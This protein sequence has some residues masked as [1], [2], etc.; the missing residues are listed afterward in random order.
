[1]K[2]LLPAEATQ[3]KAGTTTHSASAAVYTLLA[4]ASA[5]PLGLDDWLREL[6]EVLRARRA[7]LVAILNGEVVVQYCFPNEAGLM[8]SV[9]WPWQYERQSLG[10][11]AKPGPAVPTRSADGCSSFLTVAVPHEGIDWFLRL[12][13]TYHRTWTTDEEAALTL[14][15]LGL[16]Q[17]S[18]VQRSAQR[19]LPWSQRGQAQQR[20]EDAAALVSH[21]AHDFN[22]VL[23]SVLGFTELSLTQPSPGSPVHRLLTEVYTAAQQGSQLINRLS[24]FSSRKAVRDGAKASLGPAADEEMHRLRQA[25]GDAI[26]LEIAVPP[27]LPAL[28][29]DGESLRVLLHHLVENAREAIA[30]TGTVRLAAREVELTRLD[31]LELL[32]KA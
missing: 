17:L 21:L 19:W 13:D 32:G 30:S 6:R 1:M 18:P 12:E 15:A 20:L 4:N 3:T 11:S 28:A 23:T 29:I 8:D 25:W 24:Y 27:D 9:S 5:N 2:A 10:T 16:F 22:N 26:A 7:A 14:A 31:C